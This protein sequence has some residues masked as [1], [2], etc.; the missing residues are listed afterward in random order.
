MT[1]PGPAAWEVTMLPLDHSGDL[2]DCIWFLKE[3]RQYIFTFS[4]FQNEGKG[5]LSA[6]DNEYHIQS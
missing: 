1:L 3:K 4:I 2:L 6:V 5:Y